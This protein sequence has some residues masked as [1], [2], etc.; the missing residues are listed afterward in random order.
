MGVVRTETREEV[1]AGI[2]AVYGYVTDFSRWPDWAHDIL[3]CSISGGGPLR[4]GSKVDQ[5]IKAGGSTRPRILEV[6]RVAAPRGVD[7][8]GTYGPS[9]LRWGFSL[10]ERGEDR[11]EILLWVEMERRGS[12]RAMPAALLRKGIR[13]TNARELTL[14]R[15]A[16]EARLAEA[17]PVSTH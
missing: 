6:T 4:V 7:F 10:E 16:V 17:S 14:I 12:M 13:D 9:P 15:S 2:E 8:E 5:R 11:T 3:E 1:A